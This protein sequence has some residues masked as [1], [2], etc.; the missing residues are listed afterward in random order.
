MT[1]GQINEL[2]RMNSSNYHVNLVVD[3][4]FDYNIINNLHVKFCHVY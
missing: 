2:H 4:Y 3:W 1:V